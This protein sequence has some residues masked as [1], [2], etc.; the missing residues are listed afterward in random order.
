V[1]RSRSRAAEEWQGNNG[2]GTQ[3]AGREADQQTI[4]SNRPL[5]LLIAILCHKNNV[6]LHFLELLHN[7]DLE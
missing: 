4:H 3:Y 2:K 5:F 7:Q 6:G 1:L